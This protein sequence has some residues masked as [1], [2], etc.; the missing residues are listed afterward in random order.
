MS[1]EHQGGAIPRQPKSGESSLL[2][3]EDNES[4]SM[5]GKAAMKPIKV[6]L[7][8]AAGILIL[9]GGILSTTIPDH[10]PQSQLYINGNIRP[11]TAGAAAQDFNAQLWGTIETARNMEG[12]LP[13]SVSMFRATVPSADA[14][15]PV[16]IT[17]S[18]DALKA[19]S[20]GQLTPEDFLHDHV[21]FE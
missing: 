8:I 12:G 16:V 4:R 3:I 2:M 14:T 9:K 5:K 18:R 20:R 15:Q 7:L 11:E 19:L 21:N 6:T 17:F 10:T 1:F 13:S